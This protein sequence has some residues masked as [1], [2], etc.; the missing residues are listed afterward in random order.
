MDKKDEYEYQDGHSLW[1]VPK[2]MSEENQVRSPE[3]FCVK[4][5]WEEVEM[6]YLVNWHIDLKR[7]P[8]KTPKKNNYKLVTLKKDYAEYIC[9]FTQLKVAILWLTV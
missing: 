9:L 1:Q 5:Q 6:T 4:L 2:N 7:T 3:F 8:Q